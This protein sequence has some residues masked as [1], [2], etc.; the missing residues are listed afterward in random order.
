MEKTTIE[1]QL[2]LGCK[3]LPY[4]TNFASSYAD[5]V[6]WK[7]V[8]TTPAVSST[9]WYLFALNHFDPFELGYR[10]NIPEA[11]KFWKK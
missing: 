6:L 8:D 2:F 1:S 3:G 7:G 4:T 11:D 10:K 9:A 5:D